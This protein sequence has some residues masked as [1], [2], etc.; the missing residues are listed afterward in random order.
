[1]EQHTMNTVTGQDIH[2]SIFLDDENS[3]AL[4]C[5]LLALAEGK[6]DDTV[7]FLSVLRKAAQAAMYELSGEK[8]ADE[9]L[10]G[11]AY[12]DYVAS[13]HHAAMM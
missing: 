3:K 12:D 4:D 6:K 1:M 13:V 10:E 9:W 7:K 11:V 8:A 2:D 5:L